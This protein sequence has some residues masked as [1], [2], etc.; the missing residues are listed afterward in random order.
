MRITA[1]ACAA[2]RSGDLSREQRHSASEF[3][4]ILAQAA[5]DLLVKQATARDVRRS[6]CVWPVAPATFHAR[7]PADSSTSL[8]SV[9]GLHPVQRTR[10]RRQAHG[11]G[12]IF[13]IFCI[14]CPE[15][16]IALETAQTLGKINL[17][18]VVIRKI[19]WNVD[20]EQAVANE[21][22]LSWSTERGMA[23][24]RREEPE[25]LTGEYK[26]ER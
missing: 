20:G 17:F 25:K 7:K 18:H 5:A 19:A 24:S 8:P 11:A 16:E 21:E 13:V 22:A 4:V 10:I 23:R 9:K 1:F 15:V 26:C 2:L 12:S 6:T 14:L 3:V